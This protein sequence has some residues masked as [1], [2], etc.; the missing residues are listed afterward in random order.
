MEVTSIDVGE[1]DSSLIVTPEG[2]TLLID[3]GGPVGGP[4]LSE[5]D[6]V[7]TWCRLIY[8]EGVQSARRRG[9]DPRPLG[10]HGGMR[11]VLR[12]F[13]PRILWL[14]VIPPRR[15][16]QVADGGARTGDTREQHLDGEEFPFGGT[17]VRVLA[18]ARDWR[19]FR[20]AN[21][22]SLVLKVSFGATSALMEGDAEA[23]SERTW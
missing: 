19:R 21:N 15:S 20:P 3:A 16:G 9:V 2:K 7:R 1:G 14:S 22:D 11:S 4:H 17:D 6:I 12:N 23:L 13:R 8:V 5:F 18:P 10:S